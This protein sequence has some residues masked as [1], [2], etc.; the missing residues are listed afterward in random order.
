MG[1]FVEFQREQI[2]FP[3]VYELVPRIDWIKW[4]RLIGGRAE[5][6]AYRLKNRSMVIRRAFGHD[7]LYH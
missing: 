6:R 2:P 7:G 4:H 3:L 5:R 1:C